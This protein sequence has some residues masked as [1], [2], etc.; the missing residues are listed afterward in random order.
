MKVLVVEDD[1]NLR[2]LWG[3]V[4]ERVGHEARLEQ[5][6]TAAQQALIEGTF[7]LVLLDLY[8]GSDRT[9]DVGGMAALLPPDTKIVVV[10]GTTAFSQGELF[11]V[12]PA[13]AAVL[14]KP[15]DIEDLVSVCEHV[16]AGEGSVPPAIRES[17]TVELRS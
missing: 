15:V 16:G 1:P 7:D 8:L 2:A 12:T 3:A 14:R 10:T 17:A 5:S 4:F 11:S 9:I 13:V 6:E